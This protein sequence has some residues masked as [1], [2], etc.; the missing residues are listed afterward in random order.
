MRRTAQ[1]LLAAAVVLLTFF[2][3]EGHIVEVCTSTSPSQPDIVTLWLA[4]YHTDQIPNATVPGQGY[5]KSPSGNLVV[6]NFTDFCNV[7][8]PDPATDVYAVNGT[9]DR[10]ELNLKSRCTDLRD[11]THGWYAVLPDSR[12]FCYDRDPNEEVVAEARSGTQ[13][14]Y[15]CQETGSNAWEGLRITSWYAVVLKSDI[16][17]RFEMWTDDVDFILSPGS[18]LVDSKYPCSMSKDKHWFVDISVATGGNGTCTNEPNI[19]LDHIVPSTLTSC[20]GSRTE[21]PAG[22]V[23]PVRCDVGYK[24]VGQVICKETEPHKA[25]WTTSFSC[26][27]ETSTCGLP[28]SSNN[29]D[30]DPNIGG[31][32][33]PC[34]STTSLG[35]SCQY[36]CW[37]GVPVA[38]SWITCGA[39]G[40][41]KDTSPS[42]KGCP[43]Q[44]LAPLTP[45]PNT[46]APKT[47]PPSTQI[48]VT[49]S[50]DTQPPVTQS[51]DTQSPVTQSPDTQ[52]PS[53]L[54]PKTG[55]PSTQPPDT[56]SPPTDVP[57]TQ[58]PVTSPP[59]MPPATQPAHTSPPQTM[60]P[61]TQPPHTQPPLTPAPR[62]GAPVTQPPQTQP[63]VTAVPTTAPDTTPPTSQ[64]PPTQTPKVVPSTQPPNTLVPTALPIPA[65][66]A[67]DTGAPPTIPPVSITTAPD[68]E[69]PDTKAPGTKAPPTANPDTKAPDTVPQVPVTK[70]PPTATPNTLPPRT[71]VP[72]TT[73]VPGTLSPDLTAL[74]NTVAPPSVPT[75][76]PGTLSPSVTAVPN[77]LAP[78]ISNNT[79]TAVPATLSPDVTAQPNTLSPDVK[80]WSTAVPGTLSPDITAQPNTL[81][82]STLVPG[83]TMR[84]A[85]LS[86]KNPAPGLGTL[87]PDTEAP[88]GGGGSPIIIIVVILLVVCVLGMVAGWWYFK[89]RDKVSRGRTKGKVIKNFEWTGDEL[90]QDMELE[91]GFNYEAIDDPGVVET[92][93]EKD[94]SSS[95]PPKPDGTLQHSFDVAIAAAPAAAATTTSTQDPVEEP[96]ETPKKKKKKKKRVREEPAPALEDEDVPAD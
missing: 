9:V 57:K 79:V 64:V 59:T 65:T 75:V 45:S 70:V 22:T 40:K 73:T 55:V 56:L 10:Y 32:L 51:P 38:D 84:P 66:K 85:T 21:I 72:G 76:V 96:A 8:E 3:C 91:D 31:V 47:P 71:L 35:T 89:K 27:S 4:T 77:T 17:G 49:Q 41:W 95:G 87:A 69:A 88:A 68:T 81:S 20:N 62:T 80:T 52:P 67:P 18:G 23:C 24:G 19:T 63:P 86:P 6:A 44:T 16:S 94:L 33:L 46:P 13:P 7:T 14:V 36:T 15:G 53:T 25:E 34:T 39:G 78:N 11:H 54:V 74:P 43:K 58:V 83:T 30:I 28:D 42:P 1:P 12:V 92:F 37:G 2:C 82:P 61:Q 26:V 5:I 48:P 29:H 60:P 90:L 93:E 50:P